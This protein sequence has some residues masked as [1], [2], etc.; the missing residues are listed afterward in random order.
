MQ[1]LDGEIEKLEK[2]QQDPS[3]WSNIEKCSNIS[4]ELKIKTEKKDAIS[5]LEKTLQDF[6]VAL[7]LEEEASGSVS[8]QE[9][10]QLKEQAE[11]SLNN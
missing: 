5:N 3:V 9:I 8:E 11:K 2:A 4:K 6:E 1:S 7:M 10:V